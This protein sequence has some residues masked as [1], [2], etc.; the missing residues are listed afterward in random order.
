MRATLPRRNSGNSTTSST[1]ADTE[2][3]EWD[4]SHTQRNSWGN[5]DTREEKGEEQ[6]EVRRK[7]KETS[8]ARQ[9]ESAEIWREFWG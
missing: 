5:R 2:L 1:S 3:E 8:R 9:K 7:R 4:Y 6:D